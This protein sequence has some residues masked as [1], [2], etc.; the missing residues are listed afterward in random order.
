MRHRTATRLALVALVA[1][2]TVAAASEWSPD[3]WVDEDTIELR[4]TDPGADPHWFPVWVA[5]V[6][7]QVYVRLGSRAA[8]RI[9]RNTTAPIVGV[10]IAGHEFPNVRAEDAADMADRVAKEIG[11]KY[12]TDLFIRFFPHPVT[13]R[14]VPVPE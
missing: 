8:G 12:W 6:D 14:L 11:E 3:L 4:T 7:G 9:E 13:L 10:R 1:M 2:T 5:V